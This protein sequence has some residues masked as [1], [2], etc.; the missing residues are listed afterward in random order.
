MGVENTNLQVAEK[1]VIWTR[2][3]DSVNEDVVGEFI[4]EGINNERENKMAN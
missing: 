4:E 1:N 3:I 2:V